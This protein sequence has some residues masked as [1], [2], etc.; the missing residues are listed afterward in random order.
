[1]SEVDRSTTTTETS[2]NRRRCNFSLNTKDL[3]HVVSSLLLPLIL[4]VFTIVITVQQQ[5][6]AREQRIQDLNNSAQQRA[7]DRQMGIDQ[8]IQDKQ[9]AKEQRDQDEQRR[10][11][12]LKIAED[13]RKQDDELAEKQRNMSE[14]QRTHELAIE[15]ARYEKEHE[16]YLD[17]LLLNYI[18]DISTLFLSNNGSLTLNPIVRMLVRSKTLIIS[19]QLDPSRKTHIVR[20]LYEA[21]QLING[22][23]PLDLSTADFHGIQLGSEV[24]YSRM[25]GLYLFGTNLNNASFYR[26]DLVNANFSQASLRNAAF[27][28]INIERVDFS[29]AL[30]FET[31]FKDSDISDSVFNN[32]NI[33]YSTFLNSPVF[34]STFTN[35]VLRHVDLKY[36]H[37]FEYCNFTNIRLAGWNLAHFTVSSSKFIRSYFHDM[38]FVSAKIT[39]TYFI[40][41][42]FYRSHF[43]SSD[44]HYNRFENF[45]LNH[46]TFTNTSLKNT[47]WTAGDLLNVSFTGANLGGAHFDTVHFQNVSFIEADAEEMRFMNGRL[48]ASDF[49]RCHCDKVELFETQLSITKFNQ[50][51]LNYANFSESL[52]LNEVNFHGI[53][54]IEAGFSQINLHGCNFS[55]SRL[56]NASFWRSG[57]IRADFT[58]AKVDGIDF[59]CALLTNALI[60]SEQLNLVMSLSGAYFQNMMQRNPNILRN[61]GY[62]CNTTTTIDSTSWQVQPPETI[63]MMIPENNQRTCSFTVNQPVVMSQLIVV[64]QYQRMIDRRQAKVW[65]FTNTQSNSVSMHV[66]AL[67]SSNI[68]YNCS[69]RKTILT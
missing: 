60:T 66:T 41:S 17:A 14:K 55:Y 54:G 51:K 69:F 40:D 64:A 45:E 53:D 44:F 61:S 30:L 23:N 16:K 20:F 33:Q 52:I 9:I 59:S 67:T 31:Y 12:D 62:Q 27:L 57:L 5:R 7:E 34:H 18:N 8:R 46:I 63:V 21:S 32:A 42:G 19:R 37:L 1:M 39:H 29:Y 56:I 26:L 68:S 43:W 13:K 47:I 25:P 3:L 36:G 10:L 28:D 38:I 48:N 2:P 15:A 22:Q 49:S 65:V 6:I 4:S 58:N 24:Q 50:A 11:Q 35:T